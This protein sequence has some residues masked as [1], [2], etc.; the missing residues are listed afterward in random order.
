[1]EC[2]LVMNQFTYIDSLLS[3]GTSDVAMLSMLSDSNGL[4]MSIG[5]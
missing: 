5:I 3:S 2:S 4:S 1:M